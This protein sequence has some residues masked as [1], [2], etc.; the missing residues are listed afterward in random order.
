MSRRGRLVLGLVAAWLLALAANRSVLRVRG[1]SMATTLGPGDRVLTL[2]VRRPRRGEVVVVSDPRVGAQ[3]QRAQRQVKRVI[4]LP[5]ELVEI[6]GGRLRLDGVPH[7]EPHRHGEGPDGRLRVP[8]GHVV[9]LGD[10]RAASTDSRTYGPVPLDLVHRRVPLA[11]R[12]RVRR[13]AS[14]PRPAR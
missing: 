9:V 10:A 6:T 13:L 8:D 1:R 12:P 3:P 4:G 5:G 7:V 11:L 2:P 14:S